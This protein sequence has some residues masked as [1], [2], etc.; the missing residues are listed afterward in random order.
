MAVESTL[1][2]GATRR[3]PREKNSWPLPFLEM[4]FEACTPGLLLCVGTSPYSDKNLQKEKNETTGIYYHTTDLQQ[5]KT[6]GHQPPTMQIPYPAL[7]SH[8]LSII[9]WTSYAD[10]LAR[11]PSSF[12]PGS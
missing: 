9:Q 7:R 2:P 10:S 12:L 1:E 11:E 5:Q 8:R 3:V 6:G 4:L